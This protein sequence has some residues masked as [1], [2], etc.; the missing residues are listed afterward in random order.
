[1]IK[2]RWFK[3]TNSNKYFQY[4]KCLKTF[5][6][7][8]KEWEMLFLMCITHINKQFWILSHIVLKTSIQNLSQTNYTNISSTTTI[9]KLRGAW[10]DGHLSG[11]QVC[12]MKRKRN[13]V[14]FSNKGNKTD[15]HKKQTNTG[16]RFYCFRRRM[17][18][19]KNVNEKLI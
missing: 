15:H 5:I 16:Y 8:V 11:N 18:Q 9:C 4:C 2:M 6:S 7:D 17:Y 1:M 12:P 10:S 19:R 13:R 3:L 14:L